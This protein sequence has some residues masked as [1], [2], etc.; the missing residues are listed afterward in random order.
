MYNLIIIGDALID[1]HVQ[2]DNASLECNIDGKNCKLCLDFA[3]KIPITGS[4]QSVGGNGANV[5][6]GVTKLG[7]K[8]ALLA[9]LGQDSNGKL[10]VAELK[11]QNIDTDLIT[12]DP[13]A[14][15]RYS[16][17]LNYQSERTI[18][19]FHQKRKYDWP[20]KL[21]ATDW[22]YYTGLS[23]GF[24]SLQDKL[25]DFLTKHPTVRL[26]LNPGSFQLKHAPE[27]VLEAIAKSDILIINLE[28]AEQILN[29]TLNKQ[30][31][32]EA[33]IHGLLSLGAKEIVITD[34]QNGAWAGNE[35]EVWHMP[36]FPVQVVAKTGAG[37]AFSSGYVTARCLG[38]DIHEALQWGIADSCGVIGSFGAQ[39]G[40]LDQ[41]G[42]QK[43][44]KKYSSIK[45]EKIT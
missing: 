19:S 33:L 38:R 14:K 36:T 10:I 18:L 40:L 8:T 16:I 12:F 11:K 35:E 17:V 1:T 44:I 22:I 29:T 24:E 27:K 32:V 6:S 4:F 42:V 37:D 20:E 15:S 43:M 34:A 31:S 3:R 45:P 25:L 23:E 9:S 7:L 13:K 5:A 28:E 21:P 39:T 30:K 26:A 41:A 2:I